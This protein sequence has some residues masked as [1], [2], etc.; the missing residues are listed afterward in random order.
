MKTKKLK[1]LTFFNNKGGVGK[2]SLAY[3]VSWMLTELGHKVLSVDMDPQANL[4]GM[5]M[6]EDQ[7][8][9]IIEKKSVYS[10]LEPLKTGRGDIQ[11]PDII[12]F[13]LANESMGLLLGDLKLSS[14]EEDFSS[15]WP[16]CMDQDERAFRVTTA[17]SR[18]ITQAGAKMLADWAI[19]D[20]G[21]NLGAINRAVLI[22]SDYVVF[23]LGPDLFSY[24]GLKN[25][26]EFLNKWRTEWKER[27]KKAPSDMGFD[28]PEGSMTPV[29]YI[30]MRHSIRENRPVQSYQ[31]WM[32]KMPGAYKKYVIKDHLPSA[33]QDYQLGHLKDYR[34][35]MP[36]AQEKHKPMFLLK[37]GDGAI[38]SHFQ[39]VQKCYADFHELTNKITST[40]HFIGKKS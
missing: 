8:E 3:H 29:G 22:A 7:M 35:L 33:N 37:V 25:V 30:M 12:S 10:A 21:P 14:V 36:M 27:T 32:D 17:F 2:T 31:R 34:S 11:A 38:G 26:G 1:T 15:T 23:P 40:I 28:L 39:A 13:P 24:Q 19:I 18:L 20:M 5:F 9:N 16:K 6:S 4:T